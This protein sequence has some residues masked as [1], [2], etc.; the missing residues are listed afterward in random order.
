YILI[1]GFVYGA[2]AMS[3]SALPLAALFPILPL[4]AWAILMGLIGFVIVWAGRYAVIEKI[5][6]A[7]VG[8]MFLVMVGLAI[9]TLPNIPQMLTGLIPVIPQGGVVYT[10]ALAGGVGGTITLAA[11][12]YWLRE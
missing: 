12:G 5:T 9:I 4:W 2:T 6:A 8:I 1:W 3:S 7:M 10:L 11:Y